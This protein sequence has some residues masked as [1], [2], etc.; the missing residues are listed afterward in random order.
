MADFDELLK[1]ERSGWDSLCDGTGAE[2][3]GSIMT[4]DGRMI[5]AHGFALDRSQVI[6]S[7]ADAPPWAGYEITDA[8]LIRL[9]GHNAVLGYTG[10]AWRDGSEP[11]FNALMSSAYVRT[12]DGWRLALYQQT[13]IPDR[14]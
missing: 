14:A 5:L 2:F 13:A 3:Y 12:D 10:R 4:D 8:Y 1:L 6:A 7:L 11:E 9:G